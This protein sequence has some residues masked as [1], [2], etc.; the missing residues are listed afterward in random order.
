MA[1]PN[2]CSGACATLFGIMYSEC[3]NSGMSTDGALSF[4]SLCRD[5]YATCHTN[6]DCNSQ[7]NCFPM[8]D[9][10]GVRRCICNNNLMGDGGNTDDGCVELSAMATGS[11]AGIDFGSCQQLQDIAYGTIS[12]DSPMQVYCLDVTANQEN[13]VDVDLTTLDDSVVEIYDEELN[14]IDSNGDYGG[15]HSNL[16]FTPPANGMYYVVVHG[17]TIDMVGDFTLTASSEGIG[18]QGSACDGQGGEILT[19]ST[20]RCSPTS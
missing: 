6:Y 10:P 14:L 12:Y 17:F 11:T 4:A 18:Q 15:H 7:A 20:V 8:I 13:I 1:F 3:Q 2:Q 19:D 5:S 9:E 16:E